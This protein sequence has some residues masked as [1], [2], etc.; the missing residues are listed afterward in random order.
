MRLHASS[1]SPTQ[2]TNTSG[3]LATSLAWNTG[4][5]G[6]CS[7]VTT[8][9]GA[10]IGEWVVTFSDNTNFT[11]N[12]AN[13]K[14]KAGTTG[15]NFFDQTD[16]TDSQIQI[17]SVNWGGTRATDDTLTFYISANFENKTVP[18]IIYE[19]LGSYAGV[20]DDYIDVGGTGVTDTSERA[21]YSFNKAYYVLSTES[22]S[23]SFDQ[24]ITIGEAI[25]TVNAHAMAYLTQMTGGNFR[26]FLLNPQYQFPSYG[27]DRNEIM[28]IQN[29]RTE[30]INEFIIN[31]GWDYTNGEY[32]Y[33][34][35]YPP[36]DNENPSYQ[37]FGKKRTH[38]IEMP[39]MYSSTDAETWAKRY[40]FTWFM[41]V[42]LV[43]MT[44]SLYFVNINAGDLVEDLPAGFNDWVDDA[45]P[46][47]LVISTS[48]QFLS[49]NKV[50]V[51]M[52]IPGENYNSIW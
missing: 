9:T 47:G 38:T 51:I 45:D 22:I 39:G 33:T 17:P 4:S 19:L 3:S 21:N 29:Y 43:K 32:Q 50:D 48:K 40:Y 41:G 11:V 35:T 14:D 18:E 1:T 42:N 7:G 31:Y 2:R 8:Y 26:L 28:D 12:G 24:P 13:C 37:Y 46:E 49:H 6:T 20:S 23:I 36:S 30:Y 15:A 25:I 16:A 34:Y 52:W 5:S 10:Q 44:G 27:L